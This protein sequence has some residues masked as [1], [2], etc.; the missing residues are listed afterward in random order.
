M[1]TLP[2]SVKQY[3]HSPT[4]GPATMPAGLTHDHKTQP[5]VWSRIVVLSGAVKYTVAEGQFAG[6][7]YD[8]GP[9]LAGVVE[10]MMRHH[11]ECLTDDTRFLLEFYR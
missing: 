2:D 11:I 8:L 9:D 4:F 10:P 6:N 3:S 7:S 1:Q 5:D